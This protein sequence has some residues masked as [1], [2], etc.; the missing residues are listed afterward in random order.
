MEVFVDKEVQQSSVYVSFKHA[1]PSLCTPV[2][3]ARYYKHAKCHSL[4][5][6]TDC[7]HVAMHMSYVPFRWARR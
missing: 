6:V 3:Y 7:M 5:A 4:A 1:L 2:S